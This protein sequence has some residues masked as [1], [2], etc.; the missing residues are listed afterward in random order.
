MRLWWYQGKFL[1]SSV[2][3]DCK[4]SC[5][6]SSSSILTLSLGDKLKKRITLN[7]SMVEWQTLIVVPWMCMVPRILEKRKDCQSLPQQTCM[8][9]CIHHLRVILH[10]LCTQRYQVRMLRISLYYHLH[11]RGKREIAAYCMGIQH[12]VGPWTL[13]IAADG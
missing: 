4:G 7:N 8:E 10:L 5:Q 1:W 12:R 13:G 9:A 11:T 2:I 6:V 3:L